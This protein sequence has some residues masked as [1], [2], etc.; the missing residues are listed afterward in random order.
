MAERKISTKR[1]SRIKRALKNAEVAQKGN[2]AAIDTSDGSLVVAG[3]STTHFP[4]G[5]FEE[6][7]TGDGT[8]QIKV[9]LF[10]EIEV[11]L[12]GASGTGTPVDADITK[13]CYLGSSFEVSTVSTGKSI[14]GRI[15]EV[16]T[17]GVWVQM[18]VEP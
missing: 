18:L 7:L 6:T 3:V 5:Y 2:I 9:H 11:F 1:M 16:A 15:W 8:T 10:K 17:E 13:I 14:A 4:I 12:W